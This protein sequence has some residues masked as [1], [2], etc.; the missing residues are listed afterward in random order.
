MS[1]TTANG[2]VQEQPSNYDD[3]EQ[4]SGVQFPGDSLEPLISIP[5]TLESDPLDEG[6]LVVEYK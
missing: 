4:N 1:S 3:I 2:S 6:C 5:S